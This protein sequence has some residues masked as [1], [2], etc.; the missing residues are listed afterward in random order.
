MQPKIVYIFAGK[1]TQEKSRAVTN[2]VHVLHCHACQTVVEGC[3]E[4]QPSRLPRLGLK[5]H[6]QSYITRKTYTPTTAARVILDSMDHYLLSCCALRQVHYDNALRADGF[7]FNKGP[8]YL[9]SSYTDTTRFGIQTQVLNAA[10]GQGR[11][12]PK[13][14]QASFLGAL[15]MEAA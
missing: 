1:S 2:L 5:S 13:L 4:F 10:P 15:C 8:C 9:C 7:S 14:D 6:A 3:G 12:V 11:A